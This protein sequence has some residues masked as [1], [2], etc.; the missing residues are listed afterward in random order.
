MSSKD[1]KSSSS[2]AAPSL[3]DAQILAPATNLDYNLA[4][5]AA[6]NF[7]QREIA[8]DQAI[9]NRREKKANKFAVR[10]DKE[11]AKANNL[12]SRGKAKRAMRHHER[13]AIAGAEA[14]VFHRNALEAN[15]EMQRASAQL[16]APM[17][18]LGSN[19]NTFMTGGVAPMATSGLPASIPMQSS[20]TTTS[21]EQPM[22]VQSAPM[23]TTS[24]YPQQ[25][26]QQQ[27]SYAAGPVYGGSS[28]APLNT[29]FE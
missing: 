5:A 17:L 16:S 15:L 13:A 18:P 23:Y 27:S 6:T 12:A 21:V 2:S 22:Y 11:T 3:T 10:A 26:M 14:T 7:L 19:P 9:I 8:A 24:S 20:Y 1:N 28:F 25:M 29:R 4:H